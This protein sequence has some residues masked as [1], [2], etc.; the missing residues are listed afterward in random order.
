[1]SIDSTSCC[2]SLRTELRAPG[3]PACQCHHI[4]EQCHGRECDRVAVQRHWKRDHHADQLNGERHDP[5]PDEQH[6]QRH[7]RT[8]NDQRP[9]KLIVTNSCG[10]TIWP[11]I[12][13]QGGVGPGSGGFELAP[14]TSRTAFVGADW[15]G[16]VRGRIN[17]SFNSDG[18]GTHPCPHPLT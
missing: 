3:N 10:E 12:V 7:S 2:G 4:G 17:C 15:S 1:M 11:G 8:A 5:H 14:D 6:S 18:T 9:I 13:T 16:R